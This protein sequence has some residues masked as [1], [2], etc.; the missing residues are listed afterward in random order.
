MSESS[1]LTETNELQYTA[2]ARLNYTATRLEQ[3]AA[4]LERTSIST[5]LVP[6]TTRLQRENERLLS[7]LRAHPPPRPS[8]LPQR[9][10]RLAAAQSWRCAMCGSMLS[11]CFH[12]DHMTPWCETFDDGDANIAIV[13]VPCHMAKTSTEAS[14]R[15]RSTHASNGA[16]G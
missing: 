9:R 15:R 7:L 16:Q 14:H 3:V 5:D 1:L 2:S 8:M 11:E 6:D 4:R 13:C 10:L 12:A